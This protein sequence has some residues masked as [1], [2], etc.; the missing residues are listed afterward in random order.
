MES[1]KIILS[2]VI[3]AVS[4]GIVHDQ[5]T[6]HICVEYFSV[7]HPPVFPTDSPTMLALGWG[8]I[9]TWWVGASL[10]V[11]LAIAARAGRRKK[12][13]AEELW[14]PILKLLLVMAIAATLSGLTGYL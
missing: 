1:F 10:G 4:Y 8:L 13:S 5:F 14:Q 3:A 11:L 9:A 2:C 12:I 6:A 7:F